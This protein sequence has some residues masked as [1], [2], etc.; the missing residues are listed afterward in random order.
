MTLDRLS[1][2]DAHELFEGAASGLLITRPDGTIV[3]ANGIFCRWTG[4]SA[5]ELIDGRSLQSLLSVGGRIF[6]QTHWLP[7][8]QMQG[9][10][11]EVKLDVLH[12]DGHALPM[13]MN[14]V[15]REHAAGVFHSVATLVVEDRHRYER[16]LL[17]ARRRADELLAK[18]QAAHQAYVQS[19]GHLRLALSSANLFVWEVDPATGARRYEDRLS[20]LLGHDVP[21]AVHRDDVSRAMGAADRDREARELQLALAHPAGEYDCEFRLH[22]V[23]GVS[24]MVRATGRRVSGTHGAPDIFVG[25][26]QDVT[27]A[28][29]LREAAEDRALFAEQMVGIVSHDLRTPL[30]AITMNTR[31]LGRDALDARQAAA[32]DRIGSSVRRAQ[33]L[34]DDLLDFTAARLGRGL[35]VAPRTIDLC[36]VVAAAVS[37]LA[38]VHGAHRLV[39]THTGDPVCTAD[40]DRLIEV[41]GNL[42]GNAVVYGAADAAIAVTSCVD[43]AQVRIAVHNRG[44][45]ITAELLPQLFD[46]MIRGDARESGQR[47]VGLGLYIVR[48]IALAHGGDVSVASSPE[49]GTTFTVVLPRDGVGDAMP[50]AT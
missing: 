38:D 5:E 25:I 23:D 31:L 11:A 15:R 21:R 3:R 49:Q 22:G 47:N 39:H 33:R 16:E 34:V 13:L 44:P 41:L 29:S 26:M 28:A 32:L 27:A 50:A 10:V 1:L 6:C 7:L 48:Q 20:L 17:L 24:R 37:E 2:P 35:T 9:S 36:A 8:L 45:A 40:A 42:V 46:P 30:A 18:E 4:Y 43:G 19:E 12:R 14:A